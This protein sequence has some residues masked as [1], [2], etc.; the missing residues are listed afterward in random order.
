M[1]TAAV[2]EATEPD[3]D[4]TIRRTVRALRSAYD[5]DAKVL[6]R[7]LGISR[8]SLY[9]RLNGAAPWLAAEIVGLAAFF[10]VPISDF[11]EGVV[12][13]GASPT[14]EVHTRR[15]PASKR[16]QPHALSLVASEGPPYRTMVRPNGSSGPNMGTP[17]PGSAA[18]TSGTVNHAD[19]A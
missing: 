11:Y 17:K 15:Y 7:H 3:P 19:A 4:Q 13:V 14:T 1:T 10:G 6:A 8:N 2:N 16:A 9:N 5:V 12:R 18:D